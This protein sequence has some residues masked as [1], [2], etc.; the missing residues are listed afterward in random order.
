MIRRKTRVLLAYTFG[1]V[2]SI[3]LGTAG[4][5]VGCSPHMLHFLVTNATACSFNASNQS[6]C[7][8]HTF[9]CPSWA[10]KS[11]RNVSTRNLQCESKNPPC[12]FLTF[13]SNGGE[14]LINILHTYYMITS[15]RDDKFLFNYFQLW[16]SY[17]ILSATTRRIFTFHYKLTLT[18]IFVY[19][20]NDVIGDVMPYPTCLLT[21]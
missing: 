1:T 14:F 8:S 7:D 11:V 13:F 3:R 19:S 21:L 2:A 18:S 15:T 12:G 5:W 10:T 4:Q 6:R 16:R 20:T 17:A 9:R